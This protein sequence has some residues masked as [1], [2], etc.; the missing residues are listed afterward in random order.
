MTEQKFLTQQELDAANAVA[1]KAAM[2]KQADDSLLDMA[3]TVLYTSL[4]AG[5]PVGALMH[6]LYKNF[7]S[8]PAPIKEL[9]DKIKFYRN[10]TK[11][12]EGELARSG[13][14]INAVK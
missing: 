7:S 8:S 11:S 5:V 14:N 2:L 4:V 13:V 6:Y 12:L 10:A 9:D 1:I 3:K